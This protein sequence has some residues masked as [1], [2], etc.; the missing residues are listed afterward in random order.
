M[1]S[2]LM[3]YLELGTGRLNVFIGGEMIWFIQ[4]RRQKALILRFIHIPTEFGVAWKEV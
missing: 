2:I 4:Q 3:V 1:Q